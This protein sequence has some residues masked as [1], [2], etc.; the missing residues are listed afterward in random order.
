MLFS[1]D[2]YNGLNS[3]KFC[4]RFSKNGTLI[5]TYNLEKRFDNLNLA[6][7]DIHG[8]LFHVGNNS[9]NSFF[10]YISKHSQDG[11]LEYSVGIPNE[12][13]SV[14]LIEWEALHIKESGQLKY[15]CSGNLLGDNIFFVNFDDGSVYNEITCVLSNVNDQ[16]N[17]A[18]DTNIFYDGNNIQFRN[19]RNNE[20]TLF[21]LYNLSGELLYSSI[22]SKFDLS[23]LND[24]IY[25]IH[26]LDKSTKNTVVKKIA[27]IN[28]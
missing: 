24:Q 4:Q 14:D 11:S 20:L 23:H 18:Y 2:N 21:S 10:P 12:Q 6:D 13:Y 26:F 17:N 9:I 8:N 3:S 15:F 25:L 7:V 28:Y 22:N 27:I 16:E 5:G 1:G 19:Q